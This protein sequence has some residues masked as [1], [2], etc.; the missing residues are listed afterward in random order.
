MKSKYFPLLLLYLFIATI[1]AQTNKNEVLFTISNEPVYTAEF[2]RVYN[3]NLNLVQD[4]S[5]KNIDDYLSLFVN[6]KLKLKEAKSLGLQ[7]KASYIRELDGYKKQLAQ[8]F[9][10]DTKVTDALVKEAYDRLSNEVKASHILVRLPEDATPK[11]TLVAYKNILK[12]RKRSLKE[13]FEKVSKEVHNGQTIFGEDLGYFSAFRMVYPF[14]TAAYNTKVGDISNP[15]RTRFGYHILKVYDKRKS[16]GEITV[17]HIMAT[18]KPDD[19]ISDTS[20]K[21]IHDIYKKLKQGEEFEALAKQFSEDPSSANRGG[22]LPPV[23]HG[24]LSSEVFE[25][26]AFKLKN[27]G[28]ISEPIKTKF[29]WHIIKLYNKKPIQP[30]LDMKA[31]LEMK[32]KRDE[33]SHLIDDDLF[34]K[35]KQQY[36]VSSEQPDLTYFT[37]ILNDAYFKRTWSLPSDF[38][39]DKPLVKIADKQLTFQDFGS[40]LL[41]S[42]RNTQTQ[43]PFKQ[44]ILNEYNNFLTNGLMQYQE[45]HLEIE[46]PDFANI[47]SEY[48][49]GLLLF[50]LMES[51]IWNASKTDSLAVQTYYN[52]HKNDYVWPDR[53]DAVAVYSTDQSML[54]KVSKLLKDGID[55]EDIKNKFN[56][57]DTVNVIFTVGVM[58]AKNQALPENFQFKKGVSKIYNHNNSYVVVQVKDI[59]PSSLKSFDACKG[60]VISDYQTYKESNWLV[61]LKNKY[62]VVINQE[63]L[64]HVRTIINNQ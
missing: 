29:G 6:Y 19:S 14:E 61:E 10:T 16:S 64:N 24:Q 54:N 17:A 9:L 41:K 34:N 38:T 1:E 47:L 59:F 27:I 13:G 48:R 11:D 28:D 44:V 30:F 52:E 40:H 37:S 58:D 7:N 50:D 32:V 22:M 8:N 60:N 5:Q 35:L 56:T 55:I 42:Q 62:N 51:T 15:F 43:V 20:E 26:T 2:I 36:H 49:D 39:G 21:R 12:L 4:E 46:N 3:K 63:A 57:K 53:I 18:N 33:R 31:E 45:D 25:E 23:S